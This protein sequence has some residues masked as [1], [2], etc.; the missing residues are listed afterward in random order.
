MRIAAYFGRAFLYSGAPLGAVNAFVRNGA[1][2]DSEGSLAALLA[3]LPPYR[4]STTAV[5]L[6]TMDERDFPNPTERLHAFNGSLVALVHQPYDNSMLL[7]STF[8]P[9]SPP[10]PECLGLGIVR[11]IDCAAQQLYLI[12]PV[13]RRTLARCNALISPPSGSGIALPTQLLY[14]SLTG[15]C[16]YLFCE[17]AGSATV[18]MKSRNNLLRRSGGGGGDER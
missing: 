7:H 5:R 4:I 16:P 12:T 14:T 11:S 17:S 13:D 1:L 8:S 3:S 15:S 18:A 2:A 9:H 6:Q 10:L